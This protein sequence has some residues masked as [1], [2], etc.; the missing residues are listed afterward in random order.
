[1]FS[2]HTPHHID[3][4][5]PTVV[6]S[7][8]V[9]SISRF[10]IILCPVRRFNKIRKFGTTE[11]GKRFVWCADSINVLSQKLLSI[12]CEFE[13]HLVMAATNIIRYL[14]IIL[15]LLFLSPS[16]SHTIHFQISIILN[17]GI[18]QEFS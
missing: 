9:H 11:A 3:S 10:G 17:E 6:H 7:I 18:L 8:L 4:V 5:G 12:N 14:D 15:I 16:S 1:M 13:K 2:M